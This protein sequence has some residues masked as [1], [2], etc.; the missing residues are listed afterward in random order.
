MEGLITVSDVIKAPAVFVSVSRGHMIPGMLIRRQGGKYRQG[1]INTCLTFMTA[2]LEGKH[3]SSSR[4]IQPDAKRL[5]QEN[6]IQMTR[7]FLVTALT[8]WLTITVS[9]RR[10]SSA[11]REVQTFFFCFL[12]SRWPASQATIGLFMCQ[13]FESFSAGP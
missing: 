1:G 4:F 7:Y 5:R 3:L 6:Q 11:P 9:V 10:R 12:L 8:I 13:L 2:V